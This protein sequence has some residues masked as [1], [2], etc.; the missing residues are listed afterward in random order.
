MAGRARPAS[1]FDIGEL[2]S[3]M[4]DVWHGREL[5]ARLISGGAPILELDGRRGGPLRLAVAALRRAG[6]A[7]ALRAGS[8]R[9]ALG[10]WLFVGLPVLDMVAR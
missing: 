8:R 3:S 5:R 9:L 10:L 7:G 2:K 4:A 1:R 6:S